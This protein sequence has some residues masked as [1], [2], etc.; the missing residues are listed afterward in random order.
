MDHQGFTGVADADPLGFGI[1]NDG[2]GFG[3]IRILIH[4]NVTVSRPGFD[5]GHCAVLHHRADEPRSTAGNQNIHIFIHAHELLRHRPIC[6]GNELNRI[7]ID[8]AFR[9]RSPDALRNRKI[10]GKGIASSLQDAG[11]S[12]LKAQPEGVRRHV[13]SGF[14]ND[15]DHAERNPSFFDPKPIGADKAV[16]NLS[17]RVGQRAYLSEALSHGTDPVPGEPQPVH[18]TGM[19]SLRLSICNVLCIRRKNPVLIADQSLRRSKKRPVLF[20]LRHAGQI[21]F[22]RRSGFSQF[23]QF[24]IHPCLSFY[25]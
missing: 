24:H 10:G 2:N 14:I 21:I 11:V 1:E 22:H 23:L 5:D 19:H 3:Q 15:A 4:I 20:F 25:G 13:R 17:H 8:S 12:R 16:Q 7:R 6:I 18:Q 9:Q